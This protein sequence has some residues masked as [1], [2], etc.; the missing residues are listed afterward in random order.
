MIILSKVNIVKHKL[1][2][3][4]GTLV[5]I[6]SIFLFLF[7][8]SFDKLNY[9]ANMLIIC[10]ALLGVILLFS[11]IDI[12]NAVIWV[13]I[14]SMLM[15]YSLILMEKNPLNSFKW[16]VILQHINFLLLTIS[17]FPKIKQ[18]RN[19]YIIFVAVNIIM[20][21]WGIGIIY[22]I[23]P[24]VGLTLK[25]YLAGDPIVTMSMI[26]ANEPVM[27]FGFHSVAAM[28]LVQMFFL[29]Y[30]SFKGTIGLRKK[31]HF[32]FMGAFIFICICLKST[33]SLILSIV[34]IIVLLKS[35]NKKVF[36]V[37][38]IG[39]VLVLIFKFFIGSN[40]YFGYVEKISNSDG[41]SSRYQS[42]LFIPQ[43]E[44]VKNNGFIGFLDIGFSYNTDSGYVLNYIRG[45]VLNV[46]LIF[47]VIMRFFVNNFNRKY[48]I[49]CCIMIL[50]FDSI[51]TMYMYP[52]II[53]FIIF[54]NF[55]LQSLD[56]ETRDISMLFLKTKSL[57]CPQFEYFG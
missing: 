1:N 25:Y 24:I 12:K 26:R 48:A 36:R 50:I 4:I 46:L 47:I 3:T 56:Y 29:N 17:I 19:Y 35:S 41:V 42:S 43:I 23:Q 13:V 33:T 32:V 20:I 8:P 6:A 14:V 31:L 37:F 40:L 9:T 55:Y 44:Y 51:T 22:S 54:S 5:Y 21:I 16:G 38:F 53:A 57:Q 18:N 45:G 39:L 2:T 34:M 11:K 49:Y 52:Q 10:M 7:Y 15:I 28:F 30:V 27:S